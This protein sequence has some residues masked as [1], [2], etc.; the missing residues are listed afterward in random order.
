MGSPLL[1]P[2]T[3]SGILVHGGKSV[4]GLTFQMFEAPGERKM[5]VLSLYPFKSVVCRAG[6]IDLANAFLEPFAGPFQRLICSWQFLN[7]ER[8]GCA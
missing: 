2:A 7:I 6:A 1:V 4:K 5:C 3:F 8:N